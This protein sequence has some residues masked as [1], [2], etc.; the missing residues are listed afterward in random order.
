MD[1]EVEYIVIHCAATK[2]SMDIGAKEIDEWHRLRGWAMIGYHRVIRRNGQVEYGRP[3][4]QDHVLEPNEVGAHVEGF[5]SRSVGVCM[6]GGVEEKDGLT[7]EN[8]FT[9]AQ[10]GALKALVAGWRDQFPKA[11]IVG[12]TELNPGKACPSFNVQ[13]WLASVNIEREGEK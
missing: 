11:T 12:H 4:N 1:H 2:P 8:N 6:V 5:N 10:W 7:P 3:L 13:E 9:A